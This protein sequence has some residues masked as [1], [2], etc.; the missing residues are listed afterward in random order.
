MLDLMVAIPPTAWVEISMLNLN[1]LLATASEGG[2]EEKV[3]VVALSLTFIT[4]FLASRLFGELVVRFGL[5]AVLGDLIGG[6]VIGV[7]VLHFLVF[8]GD[9]EISQL[10]IR[11]V[12]G[13]TGASPEMI[14]EVFAKPVQIIRENNA[15]AGVLILLFTIGLESDLEELLKVGTQAAIV[16]V[17]GVTLPFVLG[18]LGLTMVFGVPTIPAL[19]A[20]AALTATSIG[21]TAKVM[22]DIGV[23][24]SK[25][26]QIVLGAA[27]LD[28]ILGIVILAIVISIVDKGQVEIGNVIY[29]L[30]SATVFVVAAILLNRFFGQWFVK[31]LDQLKNPSSVFIGSLIFAS[32]M[33]FLAGVAGLEGI[34]GAFAAGLVL[35]GTDKREALEKMCQPLVAIFTTIFFVSIGA[36]TDLTVINPLIPENREGLIIAAFLITVAIVGKVMAGFFVTTGGGINRLA[37]GTGMIPRGEV[38][39]VFAGLGSAT[40][41]LS[42]ALNVAIV[43]MVIATTFLAPPLL[44]VVFNQSNPDQ[45]EPQSQG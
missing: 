4:I 28:D 34:L 10:L 36:K 2:N 24:K 30:I 23:L 39:L 43:L 6:V 21:I 37:I 31:V 18:F 11:V 27:I 1:P 13:I 29:L 20:G 25:E 33:A 14:T 5:P 26:G 9:V 38:G 42:P 45:M 15:Q 41:A 16:A 3:L 19:F 40:G 22:Q 44:R 17:V 8:G 32:F 12:E 35:G 7:S